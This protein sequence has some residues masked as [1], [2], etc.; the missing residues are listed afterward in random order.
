MSSSSSVGKRES[1]AEDSGIDLKDSDCKLIVDIID[2]CSAR[3]LFHPSAFVVTGALYSALKREEEDAAITRS[4]PVHLTEQQ[5]KLVLT[6]IENACNVGKIIAPKMLAPVGA[7]VNE[8]S[9]LLK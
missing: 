8:L 7:L 9:A 2:T 6:I 4:L 5:I 3:G 1:I